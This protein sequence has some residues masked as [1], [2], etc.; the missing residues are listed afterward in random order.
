MVLNRLNSESVPME[1][2]NGLMGFLLRSETVLNLA[3]GHRFYLEA[4]KGVE[5]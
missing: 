2:V 5:L 4:L 1:G 3:L